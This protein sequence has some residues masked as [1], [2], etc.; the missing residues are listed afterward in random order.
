[1]RPAALVVAAALAGAPGCAAAPLPAP[2]DAGDPE[3]PLDG[4]D[5]AYVA[6]RTAERARLAALY[7]AEREALDRARTAVRRFAADAARREAF[8]E[9][10][11]RRRRAQAEI[12]AHLAT[13]RREALEAVCDPSA[14]ILERPDGIVVRVPTEQLFLAGTSLLRPG[15]A[16]R[17]AALAS[18]LRLGPACDVRLQVLDDAD[19]VGSDRGQLNRRRWARVH[20]SL[21]AA[22]LPHAVFLAPLRNVPYGTQ[23]DVVVVERPVPLPPLDR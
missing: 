7:D 19:G 3:P 4:A 12:A 22:G 6:R 8:L 13:A 23:V 10:L 2:G 17:L 18:A 16:E 1:V 9:D 20:D 14:Q 21:V 5:A 15:A 11:V